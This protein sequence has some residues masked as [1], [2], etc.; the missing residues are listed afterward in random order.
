MSEDAN[1]DAKPPKVLLDLE[2][3]RP[4]LRPR[5][6]QDKAEKP[7]LD[8]QYPPRSEREAQVNEQLEELVP[9][10]MKKGYYR[11]MEEPEVVPPSIELQRVKAETPA[12]PETEP[13][14]AAEPEPLEA[15]PEPRLEEAPEPEPELPTL[16]RGTPWGRYLGTI[17]VMFALA[18]LVAGVLWPPE[19]SLPPDSSGDVT[20]E[21][22]APHTEPTVRVGESTP[23]E[24]AEPVEP[25]VSV[26]PETT[27]APLDPDPAEVVEQPAE[28]DAPPPAPIV[29]E[30]P[31]V[32]S[33]PGEP[34]PPVPPGP[35]EGHPD[36]TIA[37]DPPV[38]AASP[39]PPKQA[40]P[41]PQ[42]AP[43]PTPA[44]SGQPSSDYIIHENF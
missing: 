44:R 7:S 28:P 5:L 20:L 39:Q 13:E 42:P 22:I 21:Q 36:W 34:A 8:L 18:W 24:P 25:V 11:S 19:N 32:E 9:E 12:P 2:L 27:P 16:E 43:A 31:P 37:D 10:F 30:S 15:E 23:A 35:G 17:F 41:P 26:E 40:P 38:V 4:R 33:D 14:P 6:D 29:L 1:K 3:K